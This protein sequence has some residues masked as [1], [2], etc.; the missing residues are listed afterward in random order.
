MASDGTAAVPTNIPR[1]GGTLRK[2]NGP[3]VRGSARHHATVL[4]G[5][6]SQAAHSTMPS[7]TW[8]RPAALQEVV[9]R[10]HG[11][12]ARSVAGA[13]CRNKHADA[14]SC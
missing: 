6:L 5:M 11:S 10:Q 9:L 3:S 12:A 8:A 14:L 4:V 7:M 1:M 2:N 13:G